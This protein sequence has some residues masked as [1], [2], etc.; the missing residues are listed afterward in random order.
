MLAVHSLPRSLRQSNLRNASRAADFRGELVR[1][2]KG[3][4]QIKL[5]RRKAISER[6]TKG[7]ATEAQEPER[8]ALRLNE[9]GLSSDHY[10]RRT[11]RAVL[12]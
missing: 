1:A 6:K 11:T 4:R 2:T 12:S 3:E 5:R 9:S 8:E 10:A 7:G